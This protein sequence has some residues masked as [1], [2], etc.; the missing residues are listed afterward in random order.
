MLYTECSL[1]LSN[2]WDFDRWSVLDLDLICCRFLSIF[3]HVTCDP[4]SPFA[5]S[6]LLDLNNEWVVGKKG[7]SH[8]SE[9]WLSRF[10]GTTKAADEPLA[11]QYEKYRKKRCR[12]RV[13]AT[14]FDGIFWSLLTQEVWGKTRPSQLS[15]GSK[16]I[17]STI[18]TYMIV[19]IHR[20]WH[21]YDAD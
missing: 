16:F 5:S 12:F 1:I 4:F 18:C 20:I 14:N 7:G 2:F 11:L 19:L 17:L 15:N 21:S 6:I 3:A 9:F 10:I 13:F 8:G